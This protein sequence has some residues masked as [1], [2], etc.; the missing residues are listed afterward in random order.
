VLK[1]LELSA[2][3][4]SLMIVLFSSVSLTATNVLIENDLRASTTDKVPS[5]LSFLPVKGNAS[6]P[7]WH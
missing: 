1:K 4:I 3:I 2:E 5:A 7:L 6:G